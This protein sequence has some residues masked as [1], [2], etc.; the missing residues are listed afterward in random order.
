MSIFM[1]SLW[2]QT[3]ATLQSCYLTQV[4]RLRSTGCRPLMA[5][6]VGISET[7]RLLSWPLLGLSRAACSLIYKWK[8]DRKLWVLERKERKVELRADSS[9]TLKKKVPLRSLDAATCSY[10]GCNGIVNFAVSQW[11]KCL[12]TIKGHVTVSYDR[13]SGQ[14]A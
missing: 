3:S 11:Q 12:G 10:W 4:K 1:C 7:T 8:P 2:A 14:K 5:I 6:S 9:C 13:S